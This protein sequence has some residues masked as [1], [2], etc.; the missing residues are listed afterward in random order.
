MKR[1]LVLA[2]CAVAAVVC[3]SLFWFVFNRVVGHF[4]EGP[5]TTWRL[6]DGTQVRYYKISHDPPGRDSIQVLEIARPNGLPQ[7]HQFASWHAGYSFVE[8]RTDS[9]GKVL[10]IVDTW[11]PEV[12][13]S[14]DLS[15]GQFVDEGGSHPKGIGLQTGLVLQ[16]SGWLVWR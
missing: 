5:G 3:A 14:L 16:P 7:V 6:T 2:A 13:C 1:L 11:H 4:P 15:T 10:W 8:L 9:Q 12:G